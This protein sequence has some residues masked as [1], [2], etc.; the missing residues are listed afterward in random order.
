LVWS[1]D[2]E[3]QHEREYSEMNASY[4]F[5]TYLAAGIP[6]IVNKGMA[7]QDFV[8][9]Y[10][11][12]F[13]CENMDEVLELLKDMTEEIYREKQKASQDIGELIKE[14]FFA[15]KLLIE[16]QNALYL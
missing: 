3:T 16:I 2:I 5:S 12:G 9:K 7:K 4:K 8:E 1:E 6:L 15:K 10:N 14:G 13:V 11:L